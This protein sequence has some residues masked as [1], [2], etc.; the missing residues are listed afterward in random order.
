[1]LIGAGIFMLGHIVLLSLSAGTAFGNVLDGAAAITYTNYFVGPLL[2]FFN[3]GV[4]GIVINFLMWGLIGWLLFSLGQRLATAFREWRQVEDGIQINGNQII[5]HPLRRSY[6]V[7]I[8]WQLLCIAAFILLLYLS[9][10]VLQ[11]IFVIDQALFSGLTIKQAAFDIA[12]AVLLFSTLEYG[13]IVLLR[14]Y[15]LRTRLTSKTLYQ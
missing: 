13:T 9:P 15:S 8:T 2:Y 3:L 12:K 5:R 7:R 4:L 11:R 10:T 14:L 1:M 6:F